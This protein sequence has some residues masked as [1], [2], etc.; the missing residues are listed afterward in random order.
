MEAQ[1]IAGSAARS[2]AL[3]VIDAAL[4]QTSVPARRV[5]RLAGR[6]EQAELAALEFGDPDRPLDVLFL[7]ANGFNART[8]RMVLEPLAPDLRVLAVDLRGHGRSPWWSTPADRA[9]W[10]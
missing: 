7:H 6:G 1:P 4:V 10:Y 8:Y 3:P 9:D 2:G 5:F